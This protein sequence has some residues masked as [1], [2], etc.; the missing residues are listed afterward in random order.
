MAVNKR[1]RTKNARAIK[2]KRLKLD[3]DEL[4][5]KNTEKAR[6]QIPNEVDEM[7]PL[8]PKVMP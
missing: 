6:K 8:V 5:E 4:N 7:K 1:K 2:Q 3:D